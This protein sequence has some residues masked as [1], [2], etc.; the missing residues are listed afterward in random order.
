MWYKQYSHEIWDYVGKEKMLFSIVRYFYKIRNSF[1]YSLQLLPGHVKMTTNIM[2]FLPSC[3]EIERRRRMKIFSKILMLLLCVALLCIPVAA[4]GVQSAQSSASVKS[5]GS[6]LV[7]IRLQIKLDQGQTL[8]FPL[9]KNAENVRLD[10][11]LKTPSVQAN[12]MILQL[13]QMGA[14]THTV[15]VSFE[16]ADA[17]TEKNNVLTLEVP[18]LTGFELSVEKFS[19]TV[20]LP[21]EVTGDPEFSSGYYGQQIEK[22][23]SVQVSGN[24]ISGSATQ[25]LLGQESLV[26]RYQ[27]DGQMFP[28][29]SSGESLLGGWQTV[30]ALLMVAGAVY[31]VVALLP[32]FP[33]KVRSFSPPEGLAAGDVG[34]C[35]TGCGM[36]LTM[37]VFSW[38]QL[39]YLTIHMDR[40]GRVLLQK[41][42]DM[43]SERSEFENRC[44]QKL[45]GGRQTVEGTG[46]HYAL[47]YRKMAKKSPLLHQIY[48]SRS[49]NPQIFRAL[50]V[51][52]G[53]CSG[54]VLSANIYTAGAGTVLL[55]I[56]LAL[57][58][59]VLSHFIQSGGRCLSMGNKQPLFFA[60][61]CA[62]A[63]I[64]LGLLMGDVLLAMLMVAYEC[65]IGLA[66]AVGG[67]RSETGRR[68]LAQIRGL[69]A[70]LTRG[71]IFDMQQC[72][73][74]NPSYFFELMPYAL[75]LGVEKRFARR[76]GKI[77]IAECDYLLV[78]G[79]SAMTPA[80]WAVLLRQVADLLNR[81]QRKLQY[82]QMLQTMVRK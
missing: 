38:A 69:R 62:V 54:V 51:A 58:C 67:R 13:P 27:A 9:P 44:F 15:E 65:L 24:T 63:W 39:G 50:A 42:M 36:D 17:I 72:L 76:F 16:I 41:R 75:A 70:H 61:V 30:I 49:G 40:R 2:Q 45:F 53:A 68:Y 11:K 47:L 74:K 80:Q 33:R 37:M 21:Q 23:L 19:F 14:G 81:R 34:T 79:A 31:Y 78:P 46:L 22:D 12:Q 57:L 26:L 56:G 43:G 66:A 18:L 77:E 28:S 10:G 32:S 3:F 6:C 52:A 60:I 35:L 73:E 48:R 7:T 25:P 1:P 55:A 64:G 59:G 29:Y 71:S 4:S 20:T 8:S 5:D 82:E